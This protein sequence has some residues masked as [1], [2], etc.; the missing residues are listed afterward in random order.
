M[1]A[2]SLSFNDQ[3]KAQIDPKG[4]GHIYIYICF[5]ILL[6]SWN[7]LGALLSWGSEVNFSTLVVAWDSFGA[8]LELP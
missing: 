1:R 2:R 8:L 3:H 7:F 4:L 5:F 6:F